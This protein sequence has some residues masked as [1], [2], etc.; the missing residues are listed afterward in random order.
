MCRSRKEPDCSAAVLPALPLLPCA[1][2][3]FEAAVTPLRF[4]AVMLGM[5]C[6]RVRNTSE[7]VQLDARKVGK[8]EKLSLLRET[9]ASQRT[10]QS[11]SR[12]RTGWWPLS[13][14]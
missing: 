11:G 7:L 10:A 6:V 3:V 2:A 14:Q 9:H 12:V 8:L 13:F 5:F 1:F 4:L